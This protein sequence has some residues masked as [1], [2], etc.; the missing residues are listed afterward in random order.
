MSKKIGLVVATETEFNTI[1]FKKDL[2]YKTLIEAPFLVKEVS[3][4]NR[5]IIVIN[6]GIGEINSAMAT[7]YLLDHY[8]V[9]CVLN[10]GVVGSLSDKIP[11]N[12]VVFIEK[13]F[14]YQF[15]LTAIDKVPLGY[16]K[17]FDST[18]VPIE[19]ELFTKIKNSFTNIPAVNCA[20]SNKFIGEIKEKEK[21]HN[22]YHCHICEMEALGIALT[23]HKN[24]KPVVFIKGVSDTKNGGPEEYN[25]MVSISSNFTFDV[26]L[27]VLTLI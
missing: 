27:K 11:L 14:D 9:E 12:C 18:Y 1:F 6:S 23:C 2:S 3:V 20:S 16:H 7:Q 19:S 15:D 13:I 24:N 4:N 25:K 8:E 5:T 22:K 10:Y 26:L 21:L 17:E